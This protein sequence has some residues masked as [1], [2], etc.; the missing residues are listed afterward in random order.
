MEKKQKSLETKE[1]NLKNPIQKA[2]A[3]P[4]SLRFAINANCFQC[5]G[6]TEDEPYVTKELRIE[7]AKCTCLGCPL[8]RHRP[9]KKKRGG[10]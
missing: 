6:G 1:V 3:N 5:M 10:K 7:V 8:Y 2:N 9:W 4:Q